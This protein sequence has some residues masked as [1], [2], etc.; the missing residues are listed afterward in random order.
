MSVVTVSPDIELQKESERC[1]RILEI[2]TAHEIAVLEGDFA[3]RLFA[4]FQANRAGKLPNNQ[5]NCFE[6][7]RYLQGE[8]ALNELEYD[9]NPPAE[10]GEA[11]SVE[12]A[13]QRISFPI[14]FQVYGWIAAMYSHSI[15]HEGI[16]LGTNTAGE[17]I[18]TD[19]DA[20]RQLHIRP[21]QEMYNWYFEQWSGYYLAPKRISFSPIL[22]DSASLPKTV[23]K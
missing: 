9:T 18:I 23:S 19:K 20:N 3:Q 1:V 4:I 21:Y 6:Y 12:E 14:R 2:S 22:R 5:F 17:P 7:I 16:V 10:V 15:M 13:M 11:L 8:Y